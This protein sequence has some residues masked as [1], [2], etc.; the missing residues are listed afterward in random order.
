VSGD[1][2]LYLKQGGSGTAELVEANSRTGVGVWAS[3]P[4]FFTSWPEL[5]PDG[6][7]TVC[8]TGSETGNQTQF[9]GFSASSGEPLASPLMSSIPDGRELAPG[10]FD[11]ANGDPETLLAVS[12]ATGSWERRSRV[13]PRG[14]RALLLRRR[15]RR[16]RDLGPIVVNLVGT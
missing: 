12:G 1:N 9:L 13:S 16:P 15:R 4:A 6:T 3:P 8:V 14:S 2:V 11:S 7:P 10:L 5:C